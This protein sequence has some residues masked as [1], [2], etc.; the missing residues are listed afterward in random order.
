VTWAMQHGGPWPATTAS[1]H[2]SVGVT[3][4]R[5]FQ[6]PVVYQDVPDALLPDELRG[7]NPLGIPRRVNG[8]PTTS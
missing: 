4:A 7:A 1:I 8:V 3:A 6:R 5:R 2:T